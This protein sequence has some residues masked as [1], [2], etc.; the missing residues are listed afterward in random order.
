MR[1]FAILAA[2]IAFASPLAVRAQ[3]VT[4]S[5]A[6]IPYH[7]LDL[8]T[9]DGTS[10]LQHRIARAADTVC[11]RPVDIRNQQELDRYHSCRTAAIAGAASQV[12]TVVAMAQHSPSAPSVAAVPHALPSAGLQ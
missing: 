3:D 11:E 9:N 8:T 5:R 7:D 2:A 12:D 10:A 4:Q 1:T 6:T